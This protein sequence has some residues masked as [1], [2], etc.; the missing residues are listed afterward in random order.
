M[1]E[2]EMYIEYIFKI[3]LYF[4]IVLVVF[5][6]AKN[7]Y[8][9]K[10]KLGLPTILV[11]STLLGCYSIIC[12]QIPFV[13]DRENYA[14]QF[15]DE[16]DVWSSGSIGLQIMY[17]VLY[18]FT[19]NPFVLFFVFEFIYVFVT[20]FAIR[21]FVK[22]NSRMVLLYLVSQYFCFGF[23]SLKQSIACAF[24]S[25]VF[26]IYFS[27]KQSFRVIK[28]TFFFVIAL[29][30]H[31]TALICIF[32]FLMFWLM[33]IQILKK[34]Q[35]FVILLF[36]LIFVPLMNFYFENIGLVST[37][38]EEQ[39]V[40]YANHFNSSWTSALKGIPFF[41]ATIYICVYQNSLRR[42]V[43]DTDKYLLLC[44]V[45]SLFFV[46]TSYIYWFF[47]LP[48]Y[49]YF[50]VFAI[51]SW[52]NGSKNN[53]IYEIVFVILLILTIRELSLMYFSYGGF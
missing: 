17:W 10:R 53:F 4:L 27:K 32:L 33:Q 45:I 31:E 40:V 1:A 47:R 23:F 25:L 12:G 5:L 42:R 16:W 28:C 13:S 41:V 8:A 37:S 43:S 11:A 49:L 34:I 14:M 50:P 24:I 26:S 21:I 51:I 35:Y 38:L 30:F 19:H 18:L 39:T 3:I 2:F 6:L 7:D 20:L 44:L 22:S 15:V 52:L 29:L 46:L 9:K 36:P 48:Y